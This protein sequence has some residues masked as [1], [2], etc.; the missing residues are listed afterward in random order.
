MS[1]NVPRFFQETYEGLLMTLGIS[2]SF[3]VLS[4][5]RRSFCGACCRVKFRMFFRKKT[6][7]TDRPLLISII[8]VHLAHPFPHMGDVVTL[9]L[10]ETYEDE[11][12][13]DGSTQKIRVETYF[14]VSF[15]FVRLFCALCGVVRASY[16]SLLV[17]F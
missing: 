12:R 4:M 1:D 9:K 7:L 17:S 13:L 10:S 16:C 2:S 3:T 11:N 8:C 15:Y 6:S 14:Q 5:K